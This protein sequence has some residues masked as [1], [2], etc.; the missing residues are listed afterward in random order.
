MLLLYPRKSICNIFSFI[1]WSWFIQCLMC[2]LPL[3]QNKWS[4]SWCLFRDS[5]LNFQ[6][7]MFNILY[8]ML[9]LYVRLSIC[10]IFSLSYLLWL[11]PCWM[12]ILDTITNKWLYNYCVFR[13]SI[14][15]VHH[16]MSN[17]LYLICYTFIPDL[18]FVISFLLYMEYDWYH[19]ECMF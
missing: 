16:C 8:H 7:W 14:L 5:I 4:Y 11:L 6:L 17:I 10:N 15:N 9:F 2:D 19:V 12:Y 13:S 1:Y 3:Y 18:T